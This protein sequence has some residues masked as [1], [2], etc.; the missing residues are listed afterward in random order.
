MCL[1]EHNF[2]FNIFKKNIDDE[3]WRKFMK[4]LRFYLKKNKILSVS[5]KDKSCNSPEENFM[6]KRPQHN[7]L[8]ILFEASFSIRKEYKKES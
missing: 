2:T 4:F 7:F 6:K 1:C 3:I 8:C 5:I